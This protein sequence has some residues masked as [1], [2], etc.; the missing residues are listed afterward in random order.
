MSA[1]QYKPARP[2]AKYKAKI[3]IEFIAADLEHAVSIAESATD[4]VAAFH[5]FYDAW[6]SDVPEEAPTPAELAD[7]AEVEDVEL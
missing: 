4:A 6:V 1:K 5:G 3:E 7:L 2:M